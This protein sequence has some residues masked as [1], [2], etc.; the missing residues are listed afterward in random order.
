[1][2]GRTYKPREIAARGEAIYREH[3]QPEPQALAKGSFVV[4]NVETG[5]YEIDDW[6]FEASQRLLDRRPNAVTDGVRVGHR[7][8]YSKLGPLGIL[9]KGFHV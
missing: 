9:P 4:I 7:A 3:I 6:D 2:A 1:M 5:D 8:E